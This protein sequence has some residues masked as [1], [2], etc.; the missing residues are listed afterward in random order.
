M[1]VKRLPSFTAA[2]VRVSAKAKLKYGGSRRVIEK[3]TAKATKT[4]GSAAVVRD[5]THISYKYTETQTNAK[6]KVY[7]KA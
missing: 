5:Q 2:D 7:G 3:F 6:N 1:K 4:N